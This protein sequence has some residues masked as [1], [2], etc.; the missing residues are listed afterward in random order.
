MFNNSLARRVEIAARALNLSS[1]VS[2]TTKVFS[3]TA[4][5]PPCMPAAS[6]PPSRAWLTAF[7]HSFSKI[8][9]QQGVGCRCQPED[10]CRHGVCS[11]RD[12]Q[13][14]S[15][16]GVSATENGPGHFSWPLG[17]FWASFLV[18]TSRLEVTSS[19]TSG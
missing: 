14:V 4:R 15:V 7:V 18:G 13:A 1:P 16:I 10:P 11:E 5:C 12:P 2:L 17:S 3:V 19:L 9:C 6:P 8:I